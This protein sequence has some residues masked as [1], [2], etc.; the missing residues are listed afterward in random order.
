MDTIDS[1]GGESSFGPKLLFAVTA[2]KPLRKE[3]RPGNV[4]TGAVDAC[5]R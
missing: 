4:F 5:S 2:P 1:M 3:F